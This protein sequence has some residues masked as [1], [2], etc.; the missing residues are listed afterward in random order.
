MNQNQNQITEYKSPPVGHEITCVFIIEDK[1]LLDNADG[2]LKKILGDALKSDK[3][4]ILGWVEHQFKPEGYSGVALLEESHADVHTYPEHNSI[5]FNMYSC[6]GENDCKKTFDYFK[7]H[8]L[9]YKIISYREAKVP[10]TIE[11]AKKLGTLVE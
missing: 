5:A 11:A 8:L 6:R 2:R 4:N 7:K 3:F 10:V 1:P 9:K